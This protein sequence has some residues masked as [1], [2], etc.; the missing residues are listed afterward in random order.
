VRRGSMW[1]R[2]VMES[3]NWRSFNGSPPLTQAEREARQKKRLEQ[4]AK[5]ARNRAKSWKSCY[6]CGLPYGERGAIRTKEHVLP[7]SAG[8]KDTSENIVFAHLFCNNMRGSNQSWVP[9][10]IHLKLGKVVWS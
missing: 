5:T 3:D 1:A 10:H 7:K 8:G 4:R 9:F 6:W 2:S